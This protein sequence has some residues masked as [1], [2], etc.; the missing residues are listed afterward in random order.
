MPGAP[1]NKRR[2]RRHGRAL[3]E[4]DV[5]AAAVLRT[6]T[7]ILATGLLDRTPAIDGFDAGLFASLASQGRLPAL[8]RAFPS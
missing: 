2:E 4:R 1:D 8:A 7:L 5:R 6:R 3:G